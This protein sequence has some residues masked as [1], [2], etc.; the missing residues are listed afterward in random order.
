MITF[1][2]VKKIIITYSL[3]PNICLIPLLRMVLFPITVRVLNMLETVT[4][5]HLIKHL[6]ADRLF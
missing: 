2:S 1:D 6:Q 3:M 5:G 4:V